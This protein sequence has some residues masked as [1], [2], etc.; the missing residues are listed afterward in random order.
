[1]LWGVWW[2]SCTVDWREGER[3]RGDGAWSKLEYTSVL[4]FFE[5]FPFTNSSI[6][7][8]VYFSIPNIFSPSF[9]TGEEIMKENKIHQKGLSVHFFIQIAG[10]VPSSSDGHPT[11]AGRWRTGFLK[12]KWIEWRRK[13]ITK[14]LHCTGIFENRSIGNF[15]GLMMCDVYVLLLKKR[16]KKSRKPVHQQTDLGDRSRPPLSFWASSLNRPSTA[17]LKNESIFEEKSTGSD[18]MTTRAY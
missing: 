3:E 4:S 1:M 6:E 18:C 15:L 7:N 11:V 16:K 8:T 9:W 17:S 10:L 13:W 14:L 12:R 2:D 5:P